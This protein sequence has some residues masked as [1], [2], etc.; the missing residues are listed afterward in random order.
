MARL[1]PAQ[2]PPFGRLP[3]AYGV[4]RR[5][6]ATLAL[7]MAIGMLLH[8]FAHI[9]LAGWRIGRTDVAREGALLAWP[10]VDVP[11][12]AVLTISA[13]GLGLLVALM[14]LADE[15]LTQMDVPMMATLGGLGFGIAPAAFAI[16]FGDSSN[17][18][19]TWNEEAA[20]AGATVGWHAALV[21][22][23][24]VLL[25]VAF[26]RSSAITRAARRRVQG[27]AS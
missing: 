2:A 26:A 20:R 6:Y 15:R 1:G 7:A 25:V 3:G 11:A 8:A 12:W 23:M 24:L 16:W 4:V 21:P 22:A 13:V 5:I 10:I 14:V 18:P 27:R 19:I 17:L 9:A